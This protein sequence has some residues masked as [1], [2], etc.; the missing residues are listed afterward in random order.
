[1]SIGIRK[2]FL[3]TLITLIL[4]G[5]MLPAL[6]WV[7]CDL[8]DE[9]FTLPDMMSTAP[10]LIIGIAPV[11]V[12]IFWITWSYSYIVFVGKGL[13]LEVF[14]YALHPTQVLVTTGPY[15]YTRNPMVL[16]FLFILLGVVF[17]AR[18]WSG[19]IL[20]PFVGIIVWV[21]LVTVEEKHL[22]KRFGEDYIR[23]RSNVP[24]L[25]PKLSSYS[26]KT[27]TVT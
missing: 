4:F 24:V 9:I 19:L 5:L 7:T 1:M 12:G 17:F 20:L 27:E 18:S 13:P 22:K 11:V 15:A 14:G 2:A 16:G 25:I 6:F 26:H 21:Y 8:L 23:Y 10:A 3:G